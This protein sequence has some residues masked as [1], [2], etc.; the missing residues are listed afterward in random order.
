MRFQKK[1]KGE[2]FFK[3]HL[4]NRG[5]GCILSFHF[6]NTFDTPLANIERR[7]GKKREEEREGEEE[8]KK[9]EEERLE[10]WISAWG[11]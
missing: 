10:F 6:P 5:G 7:W 3:N 9:E 4:I 1:D 2:S 11:E 8:E